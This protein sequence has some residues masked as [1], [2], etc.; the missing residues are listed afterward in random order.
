M[1]SRFLESVVEK[2]VCV[3]AVE[4]GILTFKFTPVG[5]RGWP[6]R[7]FIYRG[8][9]A[10]IEFKAEGEPLPPLQAYRLELL[11]DQK[12]PAIW[13]SRY[14]EALE[15][16]CKTFNLTSISKTQSAC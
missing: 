13:T 6:D 7:Q 3:W 14:D 9:C 8:K 10:F 5:Q 2:K 16:L 15:F 1:S 4:Q 11:H 12:I